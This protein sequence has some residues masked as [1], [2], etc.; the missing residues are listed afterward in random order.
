VQNRDGELMGLNVKTISSYY[1][2]TLDTVGTDAKLI[3]KKEF[4][5]KGKINKK[6]MLSLWEA[7][8]YSNSTT[9]KYNEK[10]QLI[11]ETTIQTILNLEKR[12]LDYINSFG[13][14]PLH[15]KIRYGYNQ[16]GK[17]ILKEIFT[18]STNALSESTGPSQKI[19][20]EYDSELLRLEKSSSSNTRVFNQNFMIEY[21]YDDQNKLIKKSKTYGSE[22][23]Y[24]MFFSADGK[25]IHGTHMATLRSYLHAYVTESVGS[26]GCVGLTDDNARALFE[27]TPSGTPVIVLADKP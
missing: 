19:I 1:Y 20:Y 25:A 24:T 22:M 17:I 12:D 16:D 3:L 7:V 18:F 26:Q 13:D 9:F 23:P 11:E 14:T 21:E 10:E 8:S 6:Y 5:T 4:G 2:S 15:E 27:W